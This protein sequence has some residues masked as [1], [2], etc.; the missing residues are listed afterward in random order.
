MPRRSNRARPARLITPIALVVAAV[1]LIVGTGY[2]LLPRLIDSTTI[3]P[4]TL[5]HARQLERS[6]DT[7]GAIAAYQRLL[8]ERPGNGQ[9][10]RQLGGL[11]FDQGQIE[12]GQKELLRALELETDIAEQLP[13][14]AESFLSTG[15]PDRLL[16][17]LGA[18]GEEELIEL[19]ASQRTALLVRTYLAQ[20]RLSSAAG[21]LRRAV[22]LEPS[23]RWVRIARLEYLL[24]NGEEATAAQ[25]LAIHTREG[26]QGEESGA[27]PL[28]D[29]EQRTAESLI[30]LL[31]GEIALRLDDSELAIRH[32]EH[33]LR[34]RPEGW[35]AKLGLALAHLKGARTE[36]AVN[37]ARRARKAWSRDPRP[38]LLLSWIAREQGKSEES[39]RHALAVL[40]RQPGEPLALHLV[41]DQALELGLIEQGTQSAQEYIRLL[42]AEASAHALLAALRLGANQPRRH[43]EPLH[44]ALSRFPHDPMLLAVA[45]ELALRLEHDDSARLYLAL[46]DATLRE[47]ALFS[48]LPAGGDISGSRRRR[49][50]LEI[51]R[52]LTQ[53]R[54]ERLEPWV[55]ADLTPLPRLASQ[56]QGERDQS[57]IR[58]RILATA[59][60]LAGDLDGAIGALEG[61]AERAVG[62]EQIS[63]QLLLGELEL[64]AGSPRRARRHFASILDA[65][66]HHR[67]AQRGLQQLALDRAS[68]N[69]R[70]RLYHLGVA[71]TAEVRGQQIEPLLARDEHEAALR[72]ARQLLSDARDFTWSYERVATI[73]YHGGEPERALRLLEEGAALDP[74]HLASLRTRALILA[75]LGEAEEAIE[76]LRPLLEQ[77]GERYWPA[78]RQAA[79]LLLEHDEIAA[80]GSI[81]ELLTETLP[82]SHPG[83]AL[84]GQ[85]ARRQHRERD[86]IES[87]RAAL[88][89]QSDQPELAL[90]L[91][92][93]ERAQ[94]GFDLAAERLSNW[95]IDHPRATP[96]RLALAID[97]ANVGRAEVAEAHYR[98]VLES[99]PE[100]ISAHNNLAL[101]LQQMGRDE[102]A[103]TSARTAYLL[104]EGRAAHAGVA[105]TL[106]WILLRN[107]QLDEALSL[108]RQAHQGFPDQPEVALHLAEVLLATADAGDERVVASSVAREEAHQLLQSLLEQR[109]AAI[110]LDRVRSLLENAR[111]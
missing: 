102:E 5:T 14:L 26:E 34:L 100:N 8:M 53:L 94:L 87:Y 13:R 62:D 98:T 1:A 58:A 16:E 95:L 83:Y 91:Y 12:S 84:A 64:A 66:P 48:P 71:A 67:L 49:A 51:E 56:D 97:L 21:E 86:A 36:Q 110:D 2:L 109:Q 29:A 70:Q 50:L 60:A 77:D 47:P 101:L 25:L 10:R 93:L 105:D 57:G 3:L 104:S 45:F 9:A 6:G 68:W 39:Q 111:R 28:P 37:W 22:A 81:A 85:I 55:M 75:S 73:L 82:H 74:D 69:E 78:A 41:T 35:R 61:R 99:D 31:A 11:L 19:P 72:L 27:N 106:G 89:R 38:Q 63:I 23:S 107:G 24:R 18:S 90:K 44:Q 76:S 4:P 30:A 88:A 46:L 15:E 65:R 42:P 32:F 33:A 96:L 52:R 103:I 40:K 108:L 17:L 43:L 20:G 7:A 59:R 92:H 54:R 80:A 79:E